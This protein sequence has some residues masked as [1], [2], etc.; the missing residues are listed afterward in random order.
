[1]IFTDNSRTVV[2][3]DAVVGGWGGYMWGYLCC[4]VLETNVNGIQ[5]HQPKALT[6]HS[7][8]TFDVKLF[9]N[10]YRYL[11]RFK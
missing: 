3:A 9:F 11:I 1:M 5:D 8:I 4:V 2:R 10:N 7:P 6:Y